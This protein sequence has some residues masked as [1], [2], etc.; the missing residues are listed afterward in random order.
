MS[1]PRVLIMAGGTGGHV[2]PALSVAAELRRRGAEIS[3]LGTRNGIEAEL[4]PQAGIDIDYVN[5]SG[6]RG[7][8]I[9]GWLL[10]PAR[11]GRALWQ[12]LYILYR[13]KPQAVL[14]LGGFVSGPGGLAAWMSGRPLLIH[15]QN[16]VAGLTNR[17]LGRIAR[18]VIQA[19]PGAFPQTPCLSTYGNPVRQEIIGLPEPGQRYAEHAGPIRLL[20]V[21]GSLG[22]R[23]LN[24]NLPRALAI[25]PEA[26]RPQVRHQSGRRHHEELLAG[27][28]EH[29]VEAEVPAFVDDMAA[30]YAWADLVICRA[31][32]LTV[33][34]LAAAGLPAILVP[35]PHAVD[36]HQTHNAAFLV[37]AGAAH[38]LPQGEMT[39][40]RL[41]EMLQEYCAEPL[42]G[43][44]KLREMAHAARALAQPEA[45]GMVAEACLAATTRREVCTGDS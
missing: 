15:E 30:A 29:E 17:L 37:R 20:V 40:A 18:Q 9:L 39:P 8:G 12:S 45:A 11:I 19:F 43:R 5:I 4:V 1:A 35:Y 7:K 3:W 6:L 44:E 36:D 38:L 23:A 2:F 10:A 41:A 27:Y 34:E 22:A 26:I 25:L 28:R 32:A 33:S 13:R 21:G 16:A 31:G 24:E 42:Q 14:G